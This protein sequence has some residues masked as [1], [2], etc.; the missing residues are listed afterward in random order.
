MRIDGWH[1][2]SFG[3]LRDYEVRGLPAGLTVLF[4][5]NEAGKTT[6]LEFIR[7]MLF[8]LT[9]TADGAPAYPPLRGGR[10]GGSLF[11]DGPDGC[12][13]IN[14]GASATEQPEVVRPDGSTGSSGD[15]ERLLGGCD[16]RL[17]ESIFAFSLTELQDFARLDI[18]S[19]HDRIF[20]AGISGAGRGVREAVNELAASRSRLYSDADRSGRLAELADQI[21]EL[22]RRAATARDELDGYPEMVRRRDERGREIDAL[23]GKIEGARAEEHR[24]Q[25][26]AEL[27]PTWYRRQTIAS[28]LEQ[29]HDS[30]DAPT[31]ED[32]TR[33]RELSASVDDARGSLLR[34][35]SEAAALIEQRDE[36]R[37]DEALLDEQLSI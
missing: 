20:S 34:L 31:L 5:P 9:A 7:Q 23:A 1:I 15:I 28:E 33:L 17:F 27:W 24:W 35:T 19:I 3:I 37:P 12:Y 8:G 22:E 26:L 18:E 29:L 2:S 16:R 32:E 30:T 6:L 25:L 14:R 4:G 13:T 11:V 10:Y 21:Q 36:L